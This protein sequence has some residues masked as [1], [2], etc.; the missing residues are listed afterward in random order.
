MSTSSPLILY[1]GLDV[2]KE[3][4]MIAVLPAGADKCTRVDRV[5]NEPKALRRYFERLAEQGEI[6][7]C[8]EASGAGYVLQRAMREWGYACEVIAPS[9][10]PQRPGHRRKHDRYDARQLARYYRNGELTPVRIPTEAEER[11]RDLV[12]CRTTFQRELLRARHFVL[13]FLTRRGVRYQTGKCHWTRGHHRWLEAL[14]RN[15]VL[16]AEDAIVFAEYLALLQYAQQRRDALDEQIEQ[17]ALAPALAAGVGRL[18]CFRGIKT[19]A[20]VTL[21]TEIVDWQRFGK[22]TQL[23]AYLGLVPCEASSDGTERRFALTKAG[24]SHCRHVLVQA[25]W[26]YRHAPRVGTALRRRQEKQPPRVI[27]HAWKAQHRLHKLYQHLA[28]R[29]GAQVAVVAVARELVGFLWA[30]MQ[31]MQDGPAADEA[32]TAA[33]QVA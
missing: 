1:V 31:E 30:A 29:K 3:T 10:I 32:L 7:A 15:G 6:R 27:T 2:H 18:S 11:V 14:S 19:A 26:A 4:V 22:P 16:I 23:M 25:A 21:M 13:K 24:N 17:L 20:A 8:Y 5:P 9:L 28:Y 12:R 33:Q